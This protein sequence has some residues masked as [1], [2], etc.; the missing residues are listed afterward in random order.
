M[1]IIIPLKMIQQ[2]PAHEII[3][4]KAS[5]RAMPMKTEKMMLA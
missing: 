5:P 2:I 4:G 1:E 3:S